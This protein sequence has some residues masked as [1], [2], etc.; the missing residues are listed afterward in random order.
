MMQ[1]CIYIYNYTTFINNNAIVAAIKDN[2]ILLKFERTT[3]AC[4]WTLNYFKDLRDFKFH[5]NIS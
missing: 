5:L 2:I 1:V 4:V 3:R